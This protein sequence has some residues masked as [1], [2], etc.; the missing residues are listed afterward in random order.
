M[1]NG[2]RVAAEQH[3]VVAALADAE[4]EDVAFDRAVL[5]ELQARHAAVAEYLRDPGPHQV[6]VDRQSGGRGCC[7]Q[8]LLQDRR[9]LEAEPRTSSPGR[10]EDLQIAGISELCEI[11]L[12]EGVLPVVDRRALADAVEQ[13][14]GKMIGRIETHDSA[15][16]SWWMVSSGLS[17]VRGVAGAGDDRHRDVRIGSE[18]LVGDVAGEQTVDLRVSADDVRGDGQARSIRAHVP[19]LVLRAGLL[20]SPTAA[21]HDRVDLELVILRMPVRMLLLHDLEPVVSERSFLAAAHDRRVTPVYEDRRVDEDERLRPVGFGCCGHRAGRAAQRVSDHG[22]PGSALLGARG[23]EVVGVGGD[24][25]VETARGV[26]VAAQVDGDGVPAGVGE[27]IGEDPHQRPGRAEPVHEQSRLLGGGVSPREAGK[28]DGG[29]G[30]TP[31][32]AC[33]RRWPALGSRRRAQS[34]GA[35]RA[36]GLRWLR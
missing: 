2:I 11:L 26:A 30:L 19:R 12:G 4:C 9:L 22:I 28:S 10:N 25:V 32:V 36:A 15:S 27:G 21:P 6:H 31:M 33:R 29:H 24:G 14:V 13:V 17:A 34:G 18:H 8:P 35:R 23:R 1:G 20:D 16:K 5:H 7:R 3:E